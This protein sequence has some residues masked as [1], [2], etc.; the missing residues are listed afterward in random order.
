MSAQVFE[1]QRPR[2]LQQLRS[3]TAPPSGAFRSL[4]NTSG[5]DSSTLVSLS[6]SRR[7]P[8]AGEGEVLRRLSFLEIVFA[9]NLHSSL[10]NS[11]FTKLPSFRLLSGEAVGAVNLQ[12]R[13]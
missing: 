13:A 9:D 3:G 11:L 1:Q 6:F 5:G 2:R 12:S 8:S 4:A 10:F 7:F